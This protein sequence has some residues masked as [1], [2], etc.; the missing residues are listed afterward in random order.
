MAAKRSL[1][2]IDEDFINDE[3]ICKKIKQELINQHDSGAMHNKTIIDDILD[4]DLIYS[5]SE[6]DI[7]CAN[8]RGI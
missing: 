6:E 7:E 8:Y 4:I 2:R 5:E 1:I 3:P